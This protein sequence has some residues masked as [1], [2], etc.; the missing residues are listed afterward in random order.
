MDCPRMNQEQ[1]DVEKIAMGEL[2]WRQEFMAEFVQPLGAFFGNSGLLTLDDEEDPDFAGLD[3]KDMEGM[4]D[5][6]L[7]KI[8]P[9]KDDVR[10]AM[11]AADRVNNLL[12]EV[13]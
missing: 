5:D 4:L 6:V 12:E 10:W 3:L 1:M 9:T 2:Y 13:Q 11:D 7:P 8:D